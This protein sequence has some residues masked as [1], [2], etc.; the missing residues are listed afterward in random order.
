MRKNLE[1]LVIKH[2]SMDPYI[3]EDSF[4]ELDIDEVF[5]FIRKGLDE[6]AFWTDTP[7]YFVKNYKSTKPRIAIIGPIYINKQ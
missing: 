6:A 1:K 7:N 4:P 5:S 3:R 2:L